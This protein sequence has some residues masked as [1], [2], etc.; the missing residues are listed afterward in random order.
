MKKLEDYNFYEG[1][2]LLIDKSIGWTS[3]DVVNKLRKLI[4][5]RYKKKLK[6]GHAGTLDPLATGL[7][8]LCSGKFTKKISQLQELDKEY[9]GTFVIGATTPSHD[10][11]TEVDNTFPVF[12]LDTEAI[13]KAAQQFTGEIMQ[14]PPMH[15]AIKID[16]KRAYKLARK[17]EIMELKPRKITI[18]AF[19]IFQIDKQENVISMDFRVVC[20]KGTYIRSLAR[21][22]GMALQNGAF[23]KNLRRTAIGEFRVEDAMAI[24]D[25]VSMLES[26]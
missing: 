14:T 12:H 7:L 22:F 26:G 4:Q 21:D 17:G 23:L 20:S 3:F 18:K 5:K 25:L 13:R 11:E 10:L 16:G 8:I 24:N 2:F 19:D 1:E 9:Q 15:S 6:L